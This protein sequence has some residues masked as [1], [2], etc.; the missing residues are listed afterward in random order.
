M[1]LKKILLAIKNKAQLKRNI[2]KH[3]IKKII[4]KKEFVEFSKVINVI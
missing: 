2:K 4:G 1:K 3:L